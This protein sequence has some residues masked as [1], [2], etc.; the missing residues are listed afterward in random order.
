MPQIRV[1]KKGNYTVLSNRCLEDPLLSNKARGLLCTMLSL[2]PTWNYTISGLSTICPKDGVDTI[3]TQIEELEFAGYI[4][5]ERERDKMGRLKG[6]VFDVYEVPWWELPIE[7]RP[8]WKVPVLNKP[9]LDAPALGNPTQVNSTQLI[10]NQVNTNTLNTNSINYQSINFD[11][12]DRKTVEE[13]IKDNIEFDIIKYSIGTE[14]LQEIVDLMVDIICSSKKTIKINSE[15]LSHDVVAEQ[16]MKLNSEHI[17]YA[18]EC[19]N[20]NRH[21]VGNYRAY[22]QTVLYNAP[23]TMDNYYSLLY[24]KNKEKTNPN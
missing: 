18:V 19:M 17:Q 4:H 1:N 13:M 20:E 24:E 14:R 3:R 8:K 11:K 9:N 10:T 22:M 2:P 15:Y 23:M 12:K 6:A 5:R 21:D 7:I 16:Y